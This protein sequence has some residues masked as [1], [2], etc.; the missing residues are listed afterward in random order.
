MC[1]NVITFIILSLA[2]I[3]LLHYLCHGKITHT[4]Y[5]MNQ[6]SSLFH[7]YTSSILGIELPKQFTYPFCYIPHPLCIRAAEEVQEYLKKQTAWEKE[8]NEGKMFGVLVVQ[9]KEGEVGFLAAFSGI[10]AG[11]N[12][13]PFFVP[14]VYDLLQPDGFFKQEEAEISKINQRIEL[15]REDEERIALLDQ[16]KKMRQEE[17]IEL[18]TQK[19]EMK[20]DKLRRNKQREAGVSSTE[21]AALIRESQF[22]KAEYKR[23]VQRWKEKI[24]VVQAESDIFEKRI[25][26]LKKERKER[27]AALQQRL[28]EQ[29]S[30]LNY[31]GE[32]RNL[33]D[34]FADTIQQ[35]PPAGAGEC[36]APKLL[37]YAYQQGWKPLAMAEFWWG[38]S[39]KCEIRQHGQYYPSCRGKCGPILSHMLQGLEVEENPMIERQQTSAEMLDIVYED[40]WLAVINKP[41]G[42]LSVPGKEIG[43]SV[44]SLMKR[45]YPNSDSPLIVHRLDFGT[46]GLLLIAKT[47]EVHCLLQKQFLER[48]IE[49]CYIAL[50]EG[51]VAEEHGIIELPLSL[52]RMDRPHQMVDYEHGK[53]AITRYRVL[54]RTENETRI[55]FYPMTGRTH[56]LRVHAA[57]RDGLHCPI[58]G[59]DLYGN[60]GER[61]CLHAESI[62]F[63]HPIE[64]RPM[65][66]SINCPF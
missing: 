29:F 64:K 40:E 57:H 14:P 47:K 54:K 39:P 37:Q 60:G 35:I 53:P 45:R 20:A 63:I 13:H 27:S 26:A 6:K 48:T 31:R 11:G 59:D 50:L 18:A 17:C 24:A 4:K 43:E 32:A 56:Q 52:N 44:Y 49:K 25:E 2:R 46:S 41:S 23:T 38:E 65:S 8:L 51:V 62:R 15:L 22:Q 58:K 1:Y 33:Y 10:L 12:K 55:A 16:L 5:I 3:K 34:I 21:E 30:M 9:N 61:L 19:E 7:P 36:A 28:F 66:F 42:L